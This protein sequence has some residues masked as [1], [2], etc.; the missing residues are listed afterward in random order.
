M[1]IKSKKLHNFLDTKGK[2]SRITYELNT[3]KTLQQTIA[4]ESATIKPTGATKKILGYTCKEFNVKNKN[5][6]GT[7]WI[8]DEAGV[9]FP[10]EMYET[11]G[12]KKSENQWLATTDGL[13]ME[14]DMVDL[15]SK[16]KKKIQMLCIELKVEDIILE[17]APYN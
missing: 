2:K 5:T 17:V 9:S 14:M 1:D 4:E 15:S 13:V 10:K 8:T 11:I 7:V 12:K 16:K 3:K 6:E